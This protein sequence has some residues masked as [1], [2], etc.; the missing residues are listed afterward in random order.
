MTTPPMNN[1]RQLVSDTA[2][3]VASLEKEAREILQTKYSEEKYRSVMRQKATLLASLYKK[4]TPLVAE[5][6]PTA[7]KNIIEERLKRFSNSASNALDLNSV[8]YMSA[9]LFPEDHKEGTPNDLELF[10][11]EHLQ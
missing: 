10:I 5:L 1:L 4:T 7:Q 8:F 2:Q 3:Q 6:P 9:L 11:T